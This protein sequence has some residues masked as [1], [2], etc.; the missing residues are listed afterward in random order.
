MSNFQ[1]LTIIGTLIAS[2]GAWTTLLAM[3]INAKIDGVN[4]RIDG[5]EARFDNLE[6][7]MNF[8]V[9]YIVEHSE[10]IAALDERT[11]GKG[12]A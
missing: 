3:Y 4:K 6:K 2:Q 7:Q 1:L 5:F 10:K 9:Q 12:A 11:K 8:V